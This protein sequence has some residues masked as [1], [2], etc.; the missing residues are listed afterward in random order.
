MKRHLL[1]LSLLLATI[2]PTYADPPQWS[3]AIHGG[4]GGIP[5][6]MPEAEVQKI[7][8]TLAHALQ[9]GGSVSFEI[10]VDDHDQIQHPRGGEP[11]VGGMAQAQELSQRFLNRRGRCVLLGPDVLSGV[12]VSGESGHNR[13]HSWP[14][15]SN[16]DAAA[17]PAEPAG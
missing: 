3:L 9:A 17:G 14:G 2:S 6:G 8:D 12:L 1:A 4:A 7:R 16:E 5:Q 10:A 13:R 15:K 11:L